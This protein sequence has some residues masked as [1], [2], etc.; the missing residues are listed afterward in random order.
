[1]NEARELKEHIRW[2]EDNAEDID[3]LRDA[4]AD[5]DE[6]VAALGDGIRG[7]CELMGQQNNI[8]KE[9][10]DVQRQ[11]RD[12]FLKLVDVFTP[13]SP[14][15]SSSTSPFGEMLKEAIRPKHPKRQKFKP[16]VVKDDPPDDGPAAA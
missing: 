6:H 15:S 2:L 3:A 8:L 4:I 13:K 10:C 1:M 9:Q 14:P 11:L 5:M 7:I 12:A 16:T